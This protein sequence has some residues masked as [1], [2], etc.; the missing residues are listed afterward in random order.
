[1]TANLDTMSPTPA[2]EPEAQ[3]NVTPAPPQGETPFANSSVKLQAEHVN[4]YYGDFQAL[5][6]ISLAVKER[7]I[8][9]E[10]FIGVHPAQN[11]LSVGH[12]WFGATPARAG[13]TM[14]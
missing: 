2:R 9:A 13:R 14:L 1:M 7:Q 3:N 8:T 6:G 12:G 4:F 11:D 5:H 10:E